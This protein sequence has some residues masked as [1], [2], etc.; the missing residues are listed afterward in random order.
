MQLNG[1]CFL[2][3]YSFIHG[4]NPVTSISLACLQLTEAPTEPQWCGSVG[5]SPLGSARRVW[6][7]PSPP[8]INPFNLHDNESLLLFVCLSVYLFATR[9]LV[10]L[11]RCGQSAWCV[12]Y[13]T[14]AH[15]PHVEE[16][17]PHVA[18]KYGP[19]AVDYRNTP[20]ELV[21]MVTV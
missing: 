11:Q 7:G 5:A 10:V 9:N 6:T 3:F 13:T 4:V 20:V 18:A 8:S 12:T 14:G 2:T 16:P 15:A 21:A 1:N 19:S 17:N